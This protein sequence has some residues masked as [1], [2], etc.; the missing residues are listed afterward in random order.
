VKFN[1]FQCS[2][3]FSFK[4]YVNHGC[5]NPIADFSASD[6]SI[7][8]IKPFE[9]LASSNC[10][11]RFK[12]QWAMIQHIETGACLRGLATTRIKVRE[13]K[14][15]AMMKEAS[16][17]D[18]EENR[19]SSD[20]TAGEASNEEPGDSSDEELSGATD[21]GRGGTSD[22]GPCEAGG[23]VQLFSLAENK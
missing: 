6:Y 17:E 15:Y 14:I 18:K 2:R 22:E 3:S 11:R 23:G 8:N 7:E 1:C 10:G 4:E 13:R 20:Q 12:T 9:C 19:T 21:V 5:L 16:E